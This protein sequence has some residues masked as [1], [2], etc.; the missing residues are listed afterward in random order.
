MS[1]ASGEL[2][3][4]RP[5]EVSDQ[6]TNGGRMTPTAIPSGVKNNVF[7]NV[8]QA[9]RMAGSTKYRKVFIHVVNDEGLALLAPKIYVAAPTKGDDR[10]TIF[11]G[12][13]T[14]TQS[15]IT[16]TEQQYG[17][18]TLNTNVSQGADRNRTSGLITKDFLK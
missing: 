4:R 15:G 8:P 5:A 17:S 14:N 7:P 12:T 2:I 9:E 6:T 16:G 1:I 3:W 11:A 18:G 10:V 13:Y